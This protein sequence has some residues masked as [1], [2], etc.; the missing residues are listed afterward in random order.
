MAL[1]GSVMLEVHWLLDSHC[2]LKKEGISLPH[3]FLPGV[4]RHKF[5]FF[6]AILSATHCIFTF[7]MGLMLHLVLPFPV[8]D[9]VQYSEEL[10]G[11]YMCIHTFEMQIV[12]RNIETETLMVSTFNFPN[13]SR[14]FSPPFKKTC[15]KN[16]VIAGKINSGKWKHRPW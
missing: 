5:S 14:F 10:Q 16:V 2:S 7:K 6:E 1:H 12:L 8:N 3:I 13:E 15:S 11:Q 4:F 9:L